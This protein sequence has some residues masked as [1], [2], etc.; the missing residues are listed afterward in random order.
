MRNIAIM[1][2]FDVPLSASYAQQPYIITGCNRYA[3]TLLFHLQ[4]LLSGQ[5]K[6]STRTNVDISLTRQICRSDNLLHSGTF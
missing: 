1:Q 2:C 3:A 6:R 4:R 5:R